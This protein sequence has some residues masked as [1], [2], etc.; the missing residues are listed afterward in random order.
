MVKGLRA[1]RSDLR[2][3]LG[4]LVAPDADSRHADP[5]S[6]RRYRLSCWVAFGASLL[7]VPLGFFDFFVTGY[8]GQAVG[9]IA[10]LIALG[11]SWL[12]LTRGRRLDPYPLIITLT[13]GALVLLVVGASHPDDMA[14]VWAPLFPLVPLYLLGATR[15]LPLVLAHLAILV[16]LLLNGAAGD[17]AH[18]DT[19]VVNTLA[20]Y[21]TAFLLALYYEN[22]RVHAFQQLSR[23]AETDPLTDVLNTRGFRKRF[24]AEFARARRAKTC[25]SLLIFDIDHFKLIN[26]RHGH[27]VGDEAIR[28]VAQL[29]I[30]NC[31][32]YDV[33]A[34]L[35]GEEFAVLL[36]ETP[37]ERALMA[38]EKFRRAVAETPLIGAWGRIELTV[39]VGADELSTDE[40]E[41]FA[42]IFS[43]AD[44]RLYRAKSDGRNRVA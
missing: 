5:L 24:E 20:S 6:R 22:G 26:D 39:S 12:A 35:G 30:V 28:H 36:P 8:I 25:L 2:R 17:G 18:A 33:V 1:L 37:R 14:L 43:R 27:D 19:A 34:R 40:E 7:I 38:A 41:S 11:G 10:A 9:E 32:G 21:A 15:G 31:R 29:L 44:R 3:D 16:F 13:S 4:Q 23:V 42:T